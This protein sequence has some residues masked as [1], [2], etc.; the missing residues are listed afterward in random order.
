MKNSLHQHFTKLVF[1]PALLVSLSACS[2]KPKQEEKKTTAAATTPAP[3]PAPAAGEIK[4]A[5][6]VPSSTDMV[7]EMKKVEE[8][9]TV[10]AIEIG[11][12]AVPATPPAPAHDT[13]AAPAPNHSAHATEGVAPEKALGWLKNGNTRFKKGF[14]R[15]D[16][17]SKK[18]IERLSKGQAPHTIVLSCSDSRVPPEI[19]FDQKLGEIFVVRT[20]GQTLDPT[21]LASMEY[22]IEHLGTRLILVMGHTSCGAVKAALGTLNGSDAGS[23][24]L[25]KLVAD[26]HPRIK[27][28]AGKEPSAH[29][30]D[31]SWA[32]ARG[33]AK[34]LLNRS[35]IIEEKVRSGQ[36]KI[37]ASLYHLDSGSVDFKE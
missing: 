20:A 30:E 16:G 25:N 8:A 10:P 18:D 13:H 21:S 28:F 36:V 33:V 23:P 26:I 6:G 27:T 34:D 11:K 5:D 17:Q 1:I 35:G 24:N 31:E 3:T 22:A 32:N 2:S 37:V 12:A 7:V 4:P 14:L 9:K 15:K 29:V 19:V